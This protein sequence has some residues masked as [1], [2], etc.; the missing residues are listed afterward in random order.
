MQAEKL[1]E[2]DDI[3]A[4]E[5]PKAIH[6]ETSLMASLFPNDLALNQVGNDLHQSQM[7]TME[8][9][10]S[11]ANATTNTNFN[12]VAG[13]QKNFEDLLSQHSSSQSILMPMS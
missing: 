11:V 12:L 9:L 10:L 2:I 7:G 13:S 5:A 6:V 4:R 1:L 3:P 8:D